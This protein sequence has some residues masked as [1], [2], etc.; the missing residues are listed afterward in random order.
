MFRTTLFAFLL[1]LALPAVAA[2]Q[3][4]Y[5]PLSVGLRWDVDVEIMPPGGIPVHGTATR[6]ITSTTKIDHYIYFIVRTTFADLPN[7]KEMTMYR[8]KSARGIFAI[9]SLDKDRQEHLEAPLP[10]DVGQSWQTTIGNMVLISTVESK[11]AVTVGDK[12]YKDCIKISSKSGD[13]K[14]TSVYF[15]APDVGNVLE[16]TK[17][18]D[19]TYKF[20]LRKFSGLK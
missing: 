20:S 5:N 12:T 2:E 17:V 11:E 6:E 10:L 4:L 16:T 15:Q 7:M 13:G 19:T 8:R 1:A 3:D 9:Q 18:G 14:F